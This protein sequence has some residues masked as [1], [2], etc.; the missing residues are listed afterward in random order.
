MKERDKEIRLMG[1][2]IKEKRKQKK[3]V[4]RSLTTGHGRY[5]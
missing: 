5:Y 4:C 1:Y 3:F 2:R